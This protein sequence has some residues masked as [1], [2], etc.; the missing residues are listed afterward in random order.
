[1]SF[2]LKLKQMLPVLIVSILIAFTITET[3]KA[4]GEK[5]VE[6]QLSGL[7]TDAATG[8][9]VADAEVIISETGAVTK[10][11][12]AGEF[13]FYDL[14]A[15]T[16]TVEVNHEG[17]ENYSEEVEVAEGGA[18]IEIILKPSEM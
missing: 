14:E 5:T 18:S 7:I 15:G 8:E 2:Q 11:N 9:A 4:D 12:A 6:A 3:L 17:Y 1:M 16:Y 13:S 10:S